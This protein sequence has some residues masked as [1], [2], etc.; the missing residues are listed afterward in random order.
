MNIRHPDHK[1]EVNHLEEICRMLKH[2]ISIKDSEICN[3]KSEIVA[4]RKN[5]WENSKHGFGSN[6]TEAM[7]E[8][9]QYISAMKN[10]ENSY[11]FSKALLEKYRRLLYSP[12]FARVDFKE[13]G[14]D[15]SEAVYL[16][17]YSFINMDTMEVV[18]HDWRAPVASI[19]YEYEKGP[20]GYE[21]G[22]GTVT[23][24]ITLKRQFKIRDSKLLFMFDSSVKID[25]EL[26]QEVLSGNASEKMKSIVA[27]I[28]REQN[29]AI[30]FN[31]GSLLAVHG[32]AGSGKTSIALHRVAYLLYQDRNLSSNNI[33]IFSPNHIFNDY[34]SN[35]LPELGEENVVQTT[36]D[37]YIQKLPGTRFRSEGFTGHMEYLLHS[38]ALGS[39]DIRIKGYAFKNSV[40]FLEALR[41][42]GAEVSDAAGRFHNIRYEGETIIRGGELKKLYEGS[43][44]QLPV[45]KRLSYVRVRAFYLLDRIQ[46]QKKTQVLKRMENEKVSHREAAAAARLEL[47]REFREVRD[48][49]H[50]MTRLDLGEVYRGF[51]RSSHYFEAGMAYGLSD[52]E[53]EALGRQ[54]VQGV[55][56]RQIYYE[57]TPVLAFLK[58]ILDELPDSAAVKHVVIDEA[59]DYSP[60][61]Y[62]VFKRLFPHSSFTILGDANQLVNPYKKPE[63]FLRMADIFERTDSAVLKLG[64][65]YRS[66]REITEF[67]KKILSLDTEVE[68]LDRPGRLPELIRLSEG[69]DRKKVLSA[70]IKA[71]QSE[72]MKSIAVLCRTAGE[73]RALYYLLGDEVE[74][75]LVV[76][77]DDLYNKG[78]NILPSY[79]CKGL[80]FDA[81]L[82]YGAD[83]AR[84]HSE[85][86]R[87]LLYTLCTRALH[88]LRIYYEGSLSPILSE[89]DRKLYNSLEE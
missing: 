17:L 4:I 6:E 51:F 32:A 25:D 7:I 23:G 12:Y 79:F 78:I 66:T 82:V 81:V 89:V 39:R 59:Q 24:D 22:E 38:E 2:E 40:R 75:G 87:N 36:L 19:F 11:R 33:M 54:A 52:D 27:T 47:Q 76:G 80:E 70:D 13:E 63:G 61:Q 20:A 60:L 30:R 26:L 37:E 3:Y 53:L 86:D 18:I 21:T 64:R 72:G 68:G 56:E 85:G 41:A 55:Y 5:M 57:D 88:I 35:V 65:T 73:C 69:S 84:Y 14:E 43:D 34:I 71:L 9:T 15:A 77:E 67:T 31:S 48:K 44:R 29:R 83:E 45:N 28:Q 74:L 49:I 50:G 1:L 58:S 62:E 8:A 46:E 16:G 42:Y 10:E